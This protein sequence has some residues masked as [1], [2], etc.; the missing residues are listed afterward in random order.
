MRYGHFIMAI[1]CAWVMWLDYSMERGGML[2]GEKR[3]VLSAYETFQSC[4][5][6]TNCYALASAAINREKGFIN[7]R[8]TANTSS[9]ETR[10]GT[11]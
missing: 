3:T 6:A 11:Q 5:S 8:S 4:D 7:V 1:F 10:D 9:A 2:E